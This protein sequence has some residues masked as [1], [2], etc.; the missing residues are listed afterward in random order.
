MLNQFSFGFGVVCLDDEQFLEFLVKRIENP[1]VQTAAKEVFIAR[2]RLEL[3]NLL[4]KGQQMLNLRLIISCKLLYYD[5]SFC[6]RRG[7]DLT[8]KKM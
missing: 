4:G 3:G 2:E 1:R 7:T 5:D 8:E 6:K